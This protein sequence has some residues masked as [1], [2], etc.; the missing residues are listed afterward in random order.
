LQEADDRA[1]LTI[2][3]GG[4][5]PTRDDTTKKALCG[6]FNCKLVFNEKVYADVRRFLESKKRDISDLNREQAEIPEK[7]FPIQNIFGTAPGLWF[8]KGKKVFV[9]LPG[10]P[11]EMKEMIS[12]HVLPKLKD[13]FNLPS[14]YHETILTTGIPESDLAAA[15][16]PIEDALPDHVTLAYLP[17]PGRVRLRVTGVGKQKDNMEQEV[18]Q[19]INEIKQAI[20]LYI[21]GYNNDTLEAI[22]GEMLKKGKRTVSTAESCTGGNIAHLITTVPG[23]SNYFTGAIIAYANEVKEKFLNVPAQAIEKHGAVSKEVIEAMAIG[24]NKLFNTDYALA[25]SGIAGPGG[26]SPGKP[27][28][29][30]WIA[31]A[32]GDRVWSKRFNLGDERGRNI[33]KA[34]IAALNMLRMGL[35]EEK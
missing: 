26:G 8:E 31:L 13:R 20:P 23:S 1:D 17:S 9:S 32:Y 12:S 29:T 6:Y 30:T 33:E 10:V 15:L 4:L 5:G 25:S 3:T 35:L 24:C 11:Y 28:G 14:L 27:V 22:V 2:L 18:K 21:Y 16:A 34:S 19:V 7:A